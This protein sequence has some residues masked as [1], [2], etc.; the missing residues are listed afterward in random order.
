MEK[1]REELYRCITE[2]G[3]SDQRTLTKSIE[4]NDAILKEMSK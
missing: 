1:I 2:Y 4:L 3:L